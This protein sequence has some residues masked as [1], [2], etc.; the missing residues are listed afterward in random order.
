MSGLSKGAG[1]RAALVS[2]A[3]ICLVA[4]SQASLIDPSQC[5]SPARRPAERQ[6]DL[7][8][9][10]GSSDIG[11]G[12][13]IRQPVRDAR[14]LKLICAGENRPQRREVSSEAS[15]VALFTAGIQAN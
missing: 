5:S 12:I 4:L 6:V 11:G 9:S 14:E 2:A 13:E 10:S 3:G 8:S 7:W 1:R 15:P